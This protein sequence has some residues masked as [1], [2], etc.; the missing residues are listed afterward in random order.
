MCVLTK[1]ANGVPPDVK[2]TY[3]VSKMD[4]SLGL[5]IGMSI[6]T[7]I[8][9]VPYTD[10]QGDEV[11]E[12]ELLKTVVEFM[13]AGAPTDTQHNREGDGRVVL[14]WVFDQET[15]DALEVKSRKFGWA[16]G[17]KVSKATFAKFKSGEYTGFSIDGVGERLPIHK[18]GEPVSP[19]SKTKHT[20]RTDI[21][22]GHEH[23][24]SI[25]DNG[26]M[27]VQQA[28][29]DGAENSHSHGIVRS[30]DGALEL[31]L[32]SGHTHVLAPNQPHLVLVAPDAIVVAVAAEKA[33]PETAKS[34]TPPA[35]SSVSPTMKT[36]AD[37][38]ID[39]EKQVAELTKRFD[40]A[41][42]LG[43]TEH[44]LWKSLD[45]AEAEAFLSKSVNDRAPVVAEFEKRN[46]TVYTA[47]DG[48][49]FRKSDD[50]RMVALAKRAD[51][52]T[53]KRM[54]LEIAKRAN[55]LE[56]KVLGGETPAHINLIKSIDREADG[57]KREAMEALI[58]QGVTAMKQLG[59][60]SGFDG[61][62]TG[63]T[64]KQPPMAAL[65]KGLETFCK[66]NNIANVWTEGMEKFKA[67]PEGAELAN[68]VAAAIAR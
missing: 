7:A 32:D 47:A 34:T 18:S 62:G 12:Q 21:V 8:D 9:G 2:A 30:P 49:V 25:Y 38:I 33:S 19:V 24:I 14:S 10:L 52:E 51:D 6:V 66:S 67:T 56:L 59:S 11:Q 68:A 28:T 44:A 27:W 20:L 13:E 54:D 42:K 65:T 60:L 35:I 43:S 23:L 61:G 63:P 15:N 31:L 39:L 53:A 36:D 5:V 29:S 57:T 1:R 3:R 50:P 26:E 40:L 55:D 58:K 41:R 4:E 46:E 22:D 64:A 17:M 16:T 48:T 45:G 37:K